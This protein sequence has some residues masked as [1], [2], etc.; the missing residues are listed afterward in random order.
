M[1]ISDTP[2]RFNIQYKRLFRKIW[3]RTMNILLSTVEVV[4][5]MTKKKNNFRDGCNNIGNVEIKD[6]KN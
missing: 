2:I 5:A 6:L 4:T 1:F 3:M